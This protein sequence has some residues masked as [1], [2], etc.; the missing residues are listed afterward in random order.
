[1]SEETRRFRL[2][3]LGLAL[4]LLAA[5]CALLLVLPQAESTA[6]GETITVSTTADE[7]DTVGSGTGCSLREAIEAINTGLPFGGCDNSN[8]LADTIFVPAGTYTLTRLAA[9]SG[10]DNDQGDL[11][12]TQGPVQ[13]LGA[14]PAETVI[15]TTAA[16]D[17]RVID[18]Y[19]ASYGDPQ[20]AELQGLTIQGGHSTEAGGGVHVNWYAGPTEVGGSTF[21]MTNVVI[22][23]N[24]SWTE[25]GGIYFSHGPEATLRNVTISENDATNG[26]GI[27]FSTRY[28]TDSLE[29]V[30]STI[31]G[32]SAQNSGG[33]LYVA[34][35]GWFSATVLATNV[36]FACND[37]G[38][39]LGGNI[40]NQ[41]AVVQLA[42]SIVAN[43]T[44]STGDNNCAG[45]PGA[46]ITSL[47]YN[48]DTGNT[49]GLDGSG[50]QIDTDP[51]LDPLDDFGGGTLTHRLPPFSPAADHIPM[52]TNGC[53]TTVVDD[54]RGI[55]RPQP[56]GG[57]C[58]VGAFEYAY[59]DL[60]VTKSAEPATT[61]AYHG[62]LT[63]TIVL[64]NSGAGKGEGVSLTD[65]LPAQVAF[66]RWLVQPAGA[67]VDAGGQLTWSG[68]VSPSMAITFTWVVS[69]I[70]SYGDVVENTAEIG[71]QGGGDSST[72]TVTVHYRVYVP[73]VLR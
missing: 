37:A 63:Y 22:R 58:D 53:G 9:G 45:E 41:Q 14:G 61:L 3:W 39:G 24:L 52:G 50:D 67:T 48:V 30:N 26:G 44:D 56:A 66:D 28:V 54:Q 47:G 33:G 70:G 42:N 29:I 38:T 7:Y 2:P 34:Y 23:N 71:H 62:E 4:I 16:W 43:G 65:T 18:F 51:L 57:D 21:A 46:E 32:N 20:H 31:S 15:S 13:I 35:G 10:W 5:V 73:I 59:A 25:G 19:N 64:S 6:L 27:Y 36:T 17:D 8:A 40:Y 11:H 72:V 49:C 68:D 12:I 55:P 1:M 69:H 60:S